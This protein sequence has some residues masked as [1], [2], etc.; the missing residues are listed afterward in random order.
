MK[1]GR[2]IV[3]YMRKSLHAY[4]SQWFQ[5]VGYWWCH[6]HHLDEHRTYTPQVVSMILKLDQ[7]EEDVPHHVSIYLSKIQKL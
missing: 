3:Q 6:L 2:G 4:C 5:Q 7:V 1:Q